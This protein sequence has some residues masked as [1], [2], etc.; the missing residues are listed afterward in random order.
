MRDRP[1]DPKL[2]SRTYIAPECSAPG[3]VHQPHDRV[4]VDSR[5]YRLSKLQIS[6]PCLLARNRI[7]L[8]RAQIVEIE[9]Q[10]VIFQ[11][12]AEIHELRAASGLLSR[13]QAVIFGAQP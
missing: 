9:D 7:Q 3:A 6:E 11:A 5:R 8:L 4:A 10:E 13:Q 2:V 1:V 12:G